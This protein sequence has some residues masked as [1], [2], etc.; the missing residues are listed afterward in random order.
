M[1]AAKDSLGELFAAL[2]RKN[3]VEAL[4]KLSSR[5]YRNVELAHILEDFE[6]P[7]DPEAI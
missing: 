7:P 6:K 2:S 4:D 3:R 5:S 1:R